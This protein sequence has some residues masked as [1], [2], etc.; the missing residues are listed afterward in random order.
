MAAS[1][2]WLEDMDSHLVQ[3]VNVSASMSEHLAD[4]NETV[5][6]LAHNLACLVLSGESPLFLAESDPDDYGH[7]DASEGWC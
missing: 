7:V 1:S 2:V 5:A 3:L 4:I 6:V